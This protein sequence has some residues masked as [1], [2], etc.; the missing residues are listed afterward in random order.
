M[1]NTDGSVL[2]YESHD[3]HSDG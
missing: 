3:C 2:S 1:S